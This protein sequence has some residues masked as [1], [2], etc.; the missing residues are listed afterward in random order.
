MERVQEITEPKPSTIVKRLNPKAFRR[1]R[2]EFLLPLDELT[3]R[4]DDDM[5]CFNFDCT[6]TRI[7]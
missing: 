1:G 3:R 4:A 2:L 6:A 5:L 7:A